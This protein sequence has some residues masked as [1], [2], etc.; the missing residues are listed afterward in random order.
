MKLPRTEFEKKFDEYREHL[1]RE[2]HCFCDSAAVLRQV[3]NHTRDHLSQINLAPGFFHTVEDALF[4]TV[5]LWADKL[6]DE[7]GARGFF[8]F[9]LFVEYNRDW[10]SIEELK[11]RK[12]YPDDHWMLKNRVP[13]TSTSIEHD[14]TRIRSLGALPSIRLRRDKYHGHFDKKYFFDQT[15]LRNESAITWNELDAAADVMGSVLNS[16]SVDFDGVFF[17]WESPSDLRRLLDAAQRAQ[18]QE[19]L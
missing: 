19:N 1:R 16:Y 17:S 5:I 11:R 10:L 13:I 2:I 3:D 15:R 6:F 7:Q 9:L 8:N 4:N 18:R 12:E 14:R